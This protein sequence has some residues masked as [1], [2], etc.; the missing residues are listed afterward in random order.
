MSNTI[1]VIT[2]NL[3]PLPDPLC[4]ELGFAV[5]DILVCEMDKERK[6]MRLVKHTD[7]TLSDEE[8]EAASNLTRVISLSSGE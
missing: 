1:D 7:Q 5:G 2:N 3:L 6:E 8:I 4:T